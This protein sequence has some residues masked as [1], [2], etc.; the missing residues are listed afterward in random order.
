MRVL[1]SCFRR[2]EAIYIDEDESEE[3]EAAV[4]VRGAPSFE[5][6]RIQPHILFLETSR[7]N[8]CVWSSL[9][10][11]MAWGRMSSGSLPLTYRRVAA[12]GCVKH[13]EG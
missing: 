4:K 11:L 1:L 3:V 7:S 2:V 10:Q 13:S 5:H 6:P 12:W 8:P 9:L